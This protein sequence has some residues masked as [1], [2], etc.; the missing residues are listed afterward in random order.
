MLPMLIKRCL[1]YGIQII[2]VKLNCIIVQYGTYQIP[3][4]ILSM[5]NRDYLESY[6]KALY[7]SSQSEA[8]DWS[9]AHEMLIDLGFE[10]VERKEG[11]RCFVNL[12][13]V[14]DN[15]E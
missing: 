1:A 10:R 7:L 6:V 9:L 4:N 15:K 3:D 5:M 14:G 12:V 8:R 11:H 2:P 13:W